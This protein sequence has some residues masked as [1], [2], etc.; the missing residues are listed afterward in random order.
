VIRKY[1]LLLALAFGLAAARLSMGSPLSSNSSP[2]PPSGYTRLVFDDEFNGRHL[3][4]SKWQPNW[5]AHS[6]RA[7]TGPV[8]TGEYNCYSPTQVTEARGELDLTVS[9]RSCEV[10]GIWYPYRSGIVESNHKFNFT[11]GYIEARMWLPAGAGLL[12]QF[13]SDGQN[14]PYDGEIDVVEDDGTDNPS[15][16]YHYSGG[17]YGRS[18]TVAGATAGW[19]TFAASW[20]ASRI[21]WFYDGRQ[22]G[23]TRPARDAPMYLILD[24]ATDSRSAPVPNRLRV[25]YVRVWQ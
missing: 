21:R 6:P 2:K 8:S 3:D 22:V 24:L 11:H 7:V 14:W 19:H 10:K 25:D 12:P 13:W 15:F 16:H 23:Q 5:L 1:V 17:V 18:V 20:N 4:T 9:A